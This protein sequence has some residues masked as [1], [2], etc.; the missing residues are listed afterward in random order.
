MNT[1]KKVI[2]M[3]LS[4]TFLNFAFAQEQPYLIRAHY[5]EVEGDVNAFIRANNEFIKKWHN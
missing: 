5:I 1:M 4:I 3:L 2:F